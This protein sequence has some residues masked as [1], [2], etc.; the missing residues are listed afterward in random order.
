VIYFGLG[1]V[2]TGRWFLIGFLMS[3]LHLVLWLGGGL[4]W[5]KFLGWW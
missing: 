4:L 1:Y 2:S 3:L 5:W